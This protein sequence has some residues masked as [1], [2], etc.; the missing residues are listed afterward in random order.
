MDV[1]QGTENGKGRDSREG[2]RGASLT[3]SWKEWGKDVVEEREKD[4]RT[5]ASLMV[6]ANWWMVV[7]LAMANGRKVCRA[8][9]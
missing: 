9:R 3:D 7:L 1:L 6:L 8:S 2:Q 4:Q 5:A